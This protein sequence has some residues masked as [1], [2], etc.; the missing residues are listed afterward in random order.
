MDT[1]TNANTSPKNAKVTFTAPLSPSLHSELERSQLTWTRNDAVLDD[2]DETPDDLVQTC[3][4]TEEA[5]SS[6]PKAPRKSRKPAQADRKRNSD[7]VQTSSQEPKLKKRKKKVAERRTS[8]EV[9]QDS[10][11]VSTTVP[12]NSVDVSMSICEAPSQD[13]P[14]HGPKRPA[15]K[16]STSLTSKEKTALIQK[17]ARSVRARTNTYN[18]MAHNFS[19]FGVRT[20]NYRLDARPTTPPLFPLRP[21]CTTCTGQ[22]RKHGYEK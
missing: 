15:K 3:T 20:S 4:P 14:T 1:T 16:R 21:F 13:V 12:S 19:S 6:I 8:A 11:M 2:D 9:D 22:Q 5:Q 18:G 10:S 7:E 17:R